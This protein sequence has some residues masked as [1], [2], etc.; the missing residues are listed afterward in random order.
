VSAEPGRR[1]KLLLRLGILGVILT[2]AG[3]VLLRTFAAH[4][5]LPVDESANV[6]YAMQVAHGHIPLAGRHPVQVQ[7]PAQRRAAQHA[8]NHP[9]LYHAL[10][11]QILRLSLHVGHP[12]AGV[13][14]ARLLNLLFAAIA[15]L[16]VGLLAWT[17]TAGVSIRGA[18]MS[19]RRRA[20]G[21]P[22]SR[23]PPLGLPA[24]CRT[25]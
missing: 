14:G 13:V 20:G 7:F 5:F 11:G 16:L 10:A 23:S 19:D 12:T 15:V 4:P 3:G 8:S 6:A 25:W 9:P 21:G 17:L 22:S 18:P 2:L 1:G 24:R